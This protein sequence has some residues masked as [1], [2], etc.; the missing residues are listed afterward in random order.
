ML[1]EEDRSDEDKIIE[2]LKIEGMV[3]LYED[4]DF[5]PVR[6]SLYEIEDICPSYDT[7]VQFKISW[8]RPH[9]IHPQAEYFCEDFKA[10]R[11]VQVQFTFSFSFSWYYNVE[12]LL[13]HCICSFT[14]LQIMIHLDNPLNTFSQGTLPDDNFTSAIM[15]I[16]SY[17]EYAGASRSCWSWFGV[18]EAIVL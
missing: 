12:S 14:I 5:L 3:R 11:I 18:S 10:P 6:Q 15:A 4:L 17:S 7:D 2:I 8:Y 9:D 13:K 16:C 1:E